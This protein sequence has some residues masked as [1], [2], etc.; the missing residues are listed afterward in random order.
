V[1]RTEKENS[2]I[3]KMK[4]IFLY[5]FLS[6]STLLFFLLL[7]NPP[8]EPGTEDDE[9][10]DGYD[11]DRENPNALVTGLNVAG[12]VYASYPGQTGGLGWIL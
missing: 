11:Y 1:E 5:V 8:K 4:S 6:V 2:F 10:Y 12:T 7:V 9:D 3:I